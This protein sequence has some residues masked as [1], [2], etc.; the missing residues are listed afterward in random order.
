M[1][2]DEV[3]NATP[4]AAGV[5][6]QSIVYVHGQVEKDHDP[7]YFRLYR[8]P[9][10]RRAYVLVRKADAVGE[11]YEW[12]AEETQQAGFHGA[13]IHSVPVKLGTEV[14]TVAASVHRVGYPSGG[15]SGP[16]SLG[17]WCCTGEGCSG[18][19]ACVDPAQ[20]FGGECGNCE[21]STGRHCAKK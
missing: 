6:D 18:D 3:I 13:R 12:T 9:H 11:L 19:C 1:K 15:T 4:G 7:D 2:L 21:Q 8:H 20:C 14:H 17:V 5:Q 16:R 10:N